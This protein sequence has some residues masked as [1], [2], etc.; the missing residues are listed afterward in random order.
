ML[1]CIFTGLL[2]S[3]LYFSADYF[4]DDMALW[5]IF[6][7]RFLQGLWTGGQQAIEQSYVSEVVEDKEKLMVLSELGIASVSGFI[8]GPVFGIVLSML[9]V[10]IGPLVKI[11]KYTSPGYL[12]TILTIVMFS[13]IQSSFREVHPHNRPGRVNETKNEESIPPSKAGIG[14]CLF[15]CLII[16]NGFAVQETITTPLVTDTAHKYSETFDWEVTA[17]YAIF[18]GSGVLSIIAFGVIHFIG[19][20]VDE[21]KLALVGLGMGALGWICLIDYQYRQIN[22]GLFFFGYVFISVN[23]PI[24]RNVV[25]TMASKIIGPNRAGGYMGWMLAVGAISRM[26]GPF[27][28][29][30]SLS[31]SLKLCFG[32]TGGLFLVSM[33]ALAIYW[34]QC[35]PH[36][37]TKKS[38][39][40]I[41]MSS[42]VSSSSIGY[43]SN[44]LN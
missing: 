39:I 7:A 21:R 8:L 11:D 34:K 3:V 30:Q 37:E 14:V 18:A 33:A 43:K 27:W 41:H 9:D 35:A 25:F 22:L 24:A 40:Q 32:S 4:Q 16:F 15:L 42:P 44:K 6:G 1:S 36:Q 19:D 17:S 28:A 29:V 38:S 20:K 23:F 5:L 26:L 31:I 2:G 13:I 10:Q 12:Q